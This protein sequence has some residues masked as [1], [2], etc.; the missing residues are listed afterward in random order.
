MP[1]LVFP[2]SPRALRLDLLKQSVTAQ[3]VLQVCNS[4]SS[5]SRVCCGCRRYAASMAR[6]KYGAT[7]ALTCNVYMVVLQVPGLRDACAAMHNLLTQPTRCS[8]VVLQVPGLHD[9]RAA[10]HNLLTRPTRC[11]VVVLQVFKLRDEHAAVQAD[12]LRARHQTADYERRMRDL[13]AALALE[14]RDTQDHECTGKVMSGTCVAVRRLWPQ[15]SG[16]HRGECE[17]ADKIS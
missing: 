3:L 16:K 17:H 14:K 11:S 9:T 6:C 5:V 1:H 7:W 8:V 2:P 13:E 15:R 10:A 4:G 12:L